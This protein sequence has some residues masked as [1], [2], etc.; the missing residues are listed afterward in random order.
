[1]SEPI[2]IAGQLE[3]VTAG[4]YHWRV[5]NRMIGGSISSSHALC[6]VDGCV[7]VDPVRLADDALRTL[8]EPRAIL[9]TARCHQRAAWR[10][11][12]MFGAEVWLPQDATHADEEPDHRYAEGDVLPGG[13]RALRTPGPEWP[14]YSFLHEGAPGVL[15]CSDLVMRA[16]AS[17]GGGEGGEAKLT[18][19]PPEYHVD[20]AETRR[21]V[22]RLLELPF[23]ILCLAHGEPIAD[24]PKSALRGL[25]ESSR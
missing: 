3:E 11:R 14:H 19:V 8:S 23:T 10:Y 1:M 15:F 18:F 13:L 12:A 21:S 20:P 9:L 24:D 16:Q 17:G 2:E 6:G 4:L 7:F 5:R 22:R 25:L